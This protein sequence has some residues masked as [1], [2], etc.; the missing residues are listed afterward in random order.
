MSLPAGDVCQGRTYVY[1]NTHVPT[2]LQV[3]RL[4][5]QQNMSYSATQK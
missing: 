1:A 2:T 5:L 4:Q 3:Y